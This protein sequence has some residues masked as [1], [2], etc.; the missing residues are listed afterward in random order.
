MKEKRIGIMNLKFCK[1]VTVMALCATLVMTGCGSSRP[2]SDAS[3]SS[4]ESSVEASTDGTSEGKLDSSGEASNDKSDENADGKKESQKSD[5]K[6]R[7]AGKNDDQS[8]NQS[9]DQ[10]SSGTSSVSDDEENAETSDEGIVIDKNVDKTKITFFDEPVTM[11][12]QRALNVRSGPS[13][14]YDIYGYLEYNT[15]VQVLGQYDK[16][17]WYLIEFFGG[18][19]FASNR[20]IAET[21]V[22]LA[23]LKAQQE[24]E[25]LA[26][27]EA[28][29]A[30][31]QANNQQAAQT[32]AQPAQA[33]APASPAPVAA[34][35]GVL[36]IGD[37]R[38]VQM[39]AAVDG[40]GCS[41]I[42]E[43]A[44]GYV[45]LN[46]TAIARADAIV[47]KGTKVVIC[48]GVNDTGNIDN[49]ANLVNAYAAV[50]AQRGAKTYFCS[51]NP[52]WE[53]PYRTEE[54]V[55]AFNSAMPGKLA[56]IT[57]LDT[58]SWLETN[59]YRLVDGLH[60]DGNTY[61]N[62]FNYIIGQI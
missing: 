16:N 38:C 57:W 14:E 33:T 6:D 28:Q 5:A 21:Q 34:P 40:G 30:A 48:L 60:Y 59:G 23:A 4:S 19:A 37:S 47:G 50:W 9:S 15:E 52:V 61:I 56:G 29:K 42:C 13:T 8:S 41:W 45:W 11:Y 1:L 24:A 12:S 20:F 3:V 25:A 36:F 17:G 46:D 31:Q 39:K 32:Q 43:N 22:D 55:K 27:I 53:N 10:A 51:V 54:Q 58:H 44:K 2:L 26:A 18:E 62:L 7:N 35:A 49:Y